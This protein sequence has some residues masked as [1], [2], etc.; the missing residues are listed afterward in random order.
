MG[1]I[2]A[3]N[4]V[5]RCAISGAGNFL[6]A[7][8]SVA[9]TFLLKSADVK[10]CASKNRRRSLG[11]ATWSAW[12]STGTKTPSANACSSAPG[13]VAT[14]KAKVACVVHPLRPRA[15]I[16]SS[17]SPIVRALPSKTAVLSTRDMAGGSTKASWRKTKRSGMPCTL[18]FRHPPNKPTPVQQ[19]VLKQLL[20]S[21][22]TCNA[23][24]A[25]WSKQNDFIAAWCDNQFHSSIS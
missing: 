25:P 11:A 14:A 13:W 6:G 7:S 19:T 20:N 1:W 8:C 21:Q 2:R 5:S 10:V 15:W 3:C 17:V 16:T 9:S 23:N 24:N 22:S 4:I 12:P 18:T